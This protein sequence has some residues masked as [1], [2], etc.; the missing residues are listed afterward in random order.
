L[1]DDKVVPLVTH[2]EGVS[3]SSFHNQLLRS[4]EVPPLKREQ[5]GKSHV[6]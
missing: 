3:A 4:G 2:R 1:P 6:W 5:G